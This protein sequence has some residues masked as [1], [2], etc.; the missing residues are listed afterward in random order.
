MW[1]KQ[2]QKNYVFRGE[3]MRFVSAIL[4]M[5][6]AF[7]LSI[8]AQMLMY[9]MTGR[10]YPTETASGTYSYVHFGVIFL[11]LLF[12]LFFGWKYWSS[13]RISFLWFFPTYFVVMYLFHWYSAVYAGYPYIS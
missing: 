10:Y 5:I 4:G 7:M 11:T 12:G 1:G 8:F 3:M 13:K 6:L 9:K 2:G